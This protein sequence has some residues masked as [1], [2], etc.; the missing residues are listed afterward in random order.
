MLPPVVITTPRVV[1]GDAE[2]RAALV[3]AVAGLPV[4]QQDLVHA[5]AGL[6]L[7]LAV[8]FDEGHA[9]LGRQLA[10]Q[11]G[12]AGAAQADQRDALLAALGVGQAEG[13]ASSE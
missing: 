5:G 10:A 3:A 8:E 7:D 11:R 1:L 2:Q 4:Q 6:A 9:A 12:L 13:A